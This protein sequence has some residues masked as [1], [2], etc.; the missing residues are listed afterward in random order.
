MKKVASIVLAIIMAFSCLT[1]AFAG[2]NSN[3][4]FGAYKH[5]YIIGI[6]GSGAAWKDCN[7]PNFDRIF[8]NNAYRYDAHTEY[9]TVSAQNWGSILTGLDYETH[10]FTNDSTGTEKNK[11]DSGKN[12]IFYY[13]RQAMPDAVLVSFNNWSNINRGIIEPDIGVKKINRKSDPLVIDAIDHYFDAG[14]QPTLMFVQLDSVDHAGHS[15]G[16]PSDQYTKAVEKADMYLGEIYDSIESNGMMEDALFILVADHGE[17]TTG[18]GGLTKEESSAIVAVAG[19]TVNKTILGESVRN[20]DVSAI[21]LYALGVKK[22]DSMSSVVP[23]GLFGASKEKT[24]AANPMAANERA[25][26]NFLYMFVRG[27][28]CLIS[29]FDWLAK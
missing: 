16:N 18:H 13:T 1:I 12:T 6:D 10:G 23:Y 3:S 17:T 7:T 27:V 4:S 29:M 19:K 9:V 5:V 25:A 28:N 14:N 24:T 2:N 15:Y 21:A 22:P 26:K 8:G 20:R 11:P